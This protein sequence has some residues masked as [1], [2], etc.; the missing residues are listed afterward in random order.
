MITFTPAY[1]LFCCSFR[2]VRH[3]TLPYRPHITPL[4]VSLEDRTR[5]ERQAAKR[6]AP[7]GN[8]ALAVYGASDCI[9]ARSIRCGPRGPCALRWQTAPPFPRLR[10]RNRVRF[11]RPAAKRPAPR[12]NRALAVYGASDRNRRSLRSLDPLRA[13]RPLRAALANGSAVSSAP[14]PQ[15]GSIPAAGSKTPGSAEEPGAR[16][17]WSQRQESNPQPTDYKSVALPLSHAGASGAYAR[18]A[19]TGY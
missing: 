18:K 4:L 7:R 9:A 14:R 15:P 17:L 8:R 1:A 10:A 6:P 16:G 11:R 19:S 3:A 2:R 12:R 13:S 5:P